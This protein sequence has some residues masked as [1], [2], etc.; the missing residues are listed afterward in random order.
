MAAIRSMIAALLAL[1]CLTD[2]WL[3]APLSAPRVVAPAQPAAR[4]AARGAAECGRGAAAGASSP[5]RELGAADDGRAVACGPVKLGSCT[6]RASPAV[7]GCIVK[8]P[9]LI[10][11]D[12]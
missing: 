5:T 8:G 1:A 3:H 6:P 7:T 4:A 2:A 10:W 9:A 11:P 12:C